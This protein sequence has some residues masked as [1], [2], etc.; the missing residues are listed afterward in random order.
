MAKSH[1]FDILNA[2]DQ[3]KFNQPPVLSSEDQKRCFQIPENLK[4]IFN[5]L[6]APTHQVCFVLLCGYYQISG[7]F[8]NPTDFHKD[9]IQIV[10]KQLD[11]SQREVNFKTY[12]RRTLH[13]HKQLLCQHLAI[14]L[15]ESSD[16]QKSLQDLLFDR[17]SR[18]QSPSKILQEIV[19]IFRSTRIEIPNYNRLAIAITQALNGFEQKLTDTIN[20]QTSELQKEKLE[21]LLTIEKT[22][23]SLI[24][25]LK[26]IDHSKEPRHIQK[27]VKEL[28]ILQKLHQDCGPT[29]RVM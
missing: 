23:P 20:L 13:Y 12:K 19:Q 22:D 8:F 21:Q 18:R 4:Q 9:D 10:C 25:R 28:Q 14:K 24:V 17:V 5:A 26:T 11:I 7:R 2:D 16:A 27:S 29:L 1:L 15:F 6:G 3:R